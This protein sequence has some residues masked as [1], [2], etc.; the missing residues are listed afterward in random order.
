MEFNDAAARELE[1]V[2]VSPSSRARRGK[3]RAL[4]ALR[5]GEEVLDIGCGPGFLADEMAVEVGPRGRV[6]GVDRS[7]DMLI[8]ARRRCAERPPAAFQKGEA[9]ELP[10]PDSSFDAAAVVQVY[11]FVADI[12]RA[13]AE[14]YR[15]LRPGGRA[16]VV[17]TDWASLVWEA[18]D[19]GRATRIL[20]AWD[21]HLADPHLPRRLPGLL[22]D[23]G[24]DLVTAEPYATLSL[25]PEPF[26]GGLAKMI[27]GFVPGRGGVTAEEA[28]AWI[29]D[30]ADA[31]AKGGYFFS[32]TAY[33]FL[34][35]RE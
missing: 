34:A 21:E 25:E 33:V 16:V 29:A 19:R 12:R 2:Y 15:V 9:T 22:R 4:L 10:F 6:E 31:A 30:L 32:L 18:A 26:S 11:E 17:D 14:L 24:F 1:A 8:R 7:E 3:V 27:A 23:A 28:K 13:L 20:R 5:P 35:R